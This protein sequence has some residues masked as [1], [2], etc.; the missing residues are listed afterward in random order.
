MSRVYIILVNWNG[1]RD[2]IECLESLFRLN[3]PDFKV[4]VCDNASQDNSMDRI[5]DWARGSLEAGCS[6][7]ELRQ[8]S[9]PPCAKPIPLLKILPGET[10]DLS[11]RN[12]RL[13][14]LEAGS[15]LGFAGANNLGLRLALHSGDIDYAWLLNNDTVVKPD[16]LS[17]L[18]QRMQ[19]AHDAGI[20]GS[21]LLHYDDPKVVQ[22]L[23][24][25]TYSSWTA[26]M[27]YIGQGIACDA[28]LPGRVVENR[29][30]YV[31]GA[32]MLVS[33]S[34]L[35]QIGLMNEK[36]FLYFEELDWATRARGRFSLVY[37]P[38]SLVYHKS[39]AA[40][41][42]SEL[43]RNRSTLTEFYSTRSRILFTRTFHSWMLVTV[44]AAIA[45]SCLRWLVKA[46][47]RKCS[48]M[49]RGFASGLSMRITRDQHANQV[50]NAI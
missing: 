42:S 24:G 16:A 8:L 31:A 23:G 22:A 28:L 15:N 9:L 25:S 32:S 36:Y 21:T 43:A 37:S 13:I 46:N 20:C 35:Q 12:E 50:R 41:G 38:A 18:V 4:I 27:G 44:C 47:F 30:K 33:R 10:L 48:A 5:V 11:T 14:L 29:M 40:T 19:Q 34:L 26:R 6:N 17:A 2:T 39:G 1:W 3:Y 45:L 49:L 7:P